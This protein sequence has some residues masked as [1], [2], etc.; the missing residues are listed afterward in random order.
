[1]NTYDLDQVVDLH[2]KC[3][4][5][6]RSTKLG[7]KFLKKFYSWYT[8]YHPELS[9]VSEGAGE[10]VGFICGTLGSG[11]G[12]QRFKFTLPIIIQSLINNP[13]LIFNKV[14]FKS[15][16]VL[17][18]AL[19]IK[20]KSIPNDQKPAGKKG[21]LDSIA[22]D[23]RARGHSIGI[24]LVQKFEEAAREQGA[25]YLS[26]GVE[27]DNIPARKLYEKCGWRL[28]FEKLDENSASYMKD[29]N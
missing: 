1:M 24:L 29:I 19:K 11:G 26:L 28:A 23:S 22:I 5:T 21:A 7:K 27:A 17:I 14:T 16:K 8:I 15:W 4:P 25:T 13:L 9:F 6:S 20:K 12:Q 18:N 3:F 10:V 2:K